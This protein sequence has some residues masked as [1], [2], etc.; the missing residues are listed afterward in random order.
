M[1]GEQKKGKENQNTTRI[2]ATKE[3][4]KAVRPMID[5]SFGK[6]QTME[7]TANIFKHIAVNK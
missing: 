5:A 2:F 3:F 7:L 4:E 6:M 1:S